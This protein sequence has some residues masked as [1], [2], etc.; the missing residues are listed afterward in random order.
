MWFVILWSDLSG[1]IFCYFYAMRA[2]A[3]GSGQPWRGESRD[4]RINFRGCS[5]ANNRGGEVRVGQRKLKSS[6]MERLSGW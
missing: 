4:G 1:S 2:A 6:P 5:E 3:I